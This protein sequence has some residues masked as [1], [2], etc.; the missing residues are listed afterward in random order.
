MVSSEPSPGKAISVCL[1]GEVYSVSAF[2]GEGWTVILGTQ[3][4]SQSLLRVGSFCVDV[5]YTPQE[6]CWMVA[7]P[8][9]GA[10][11]EAAQDPELYVGFHK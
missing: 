11:G 2:W 8:K 6:R 1:T 4:A 7:E 9:G 5:C 10:G 3:L